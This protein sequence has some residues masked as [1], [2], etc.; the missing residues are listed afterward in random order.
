[1][2]RPGKCTVILE[3]GL[4][5][6]QADLRAA[7]KTPANDIGVLLRNPEAQV[8]T[9]NAA[10]IKEVLDSHLGFEIDG[11]NKGMPVK[12]ESLLHQ[13]QARSENPIVYVTEDL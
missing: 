10:N 8:C 6:K 3:D 9:V 7:N 1:W 5:A 12:R 4:P 11:P 13:M 2:N